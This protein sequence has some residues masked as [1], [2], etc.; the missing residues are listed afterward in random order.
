MGQTCNRQHP[1]TFVLTAGETNDVAAC[2]A[3]TTT[4]GMA[5]N[6]GTRIHVDTDLTAS[7]TAVTFNLY[8]ASTPDGVWAKS[9]TFLQPAGLIT[10]IDVI[11][12]TGYKF[13]LRADPGGATPTI[14]V[15]IRVTT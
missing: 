6:G 12:T 7:V 8:I 5:F 2:V 9:K 14:T 4:S 11:D 15:G 13:R 10:A 3:I 1:I